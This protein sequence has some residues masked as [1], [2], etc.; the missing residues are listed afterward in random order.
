MAFYESVVI[1]R[2]ELTVSQIENLINSLSENLIN[3]LTKSQKELVA[4]FIL[5]FDMF[6]I[7]F[8]FSVDREVPNS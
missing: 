7:S 3:L 4:I 5:P 1:A 8:I 6:E 2:P